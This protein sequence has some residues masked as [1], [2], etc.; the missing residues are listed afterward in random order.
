MI[1]K[2]TRKTERDGTM[3]REE[4]NGRSDQDDDRSILFPIRLPSPPYASP[5]LPEGN[6]CP[7]RTDH[8]CTRLDWENTHTAG[9]YSRQSVSL[10]IRQD[11]TYD[12]IECMILFAF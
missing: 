12:V 11:G 4:E 6:A 1:K 9:S 10:L 2:K 3:E 8:K 7:T 5:P